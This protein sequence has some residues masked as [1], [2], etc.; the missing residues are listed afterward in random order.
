MPTPAVR[1]R[2]EESKPKVYRFQ[3]K[4]RRLASRHPPAAGKRLQ[5]LVGARV[6]CTGV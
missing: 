3:A 5:A 4:T 2:S 6:F 1:G